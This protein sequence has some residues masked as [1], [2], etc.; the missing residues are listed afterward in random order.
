MNTH[1]IIQIANCAY[2]VEARL[3]VPEDYVV[4]SGTFAECES[5]YGRI[6]Y[7]LNHYGR[8]LGLEEHV[9]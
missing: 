3:V 1:C 4:Y 6:E 2:I 9:F 5:A 7:D 8:V